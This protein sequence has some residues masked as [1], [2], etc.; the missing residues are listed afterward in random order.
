MTLHHDH[1][2]ACCAPDHAG[3]G[4]FVEAYRIAQEKS[5][6]AGQLLAAGGELLCLLRA[7]MLACPGCKGSGESEGDSAMPCLLC[8]PWRRAEG[9]WVSAVWKWRTR[10]E[11]SDA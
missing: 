7:Q 3:P 4:H 1:D 2:Y 10:E 5:D 6:P 11:D 8:L 9:R